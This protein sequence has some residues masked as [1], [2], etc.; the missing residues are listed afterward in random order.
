MCTKHT[1]IYFLQIHLFA[2]G[3]CQ[4]VNLIAGLINTMHSGLFAWS[5][6]AGG[7]SAQF[8]CPRDCAVKGESIGKTPL[9]LYRANIQIQV[10][11]QR[12]D[13]FALTFRFKAQQCINDQNLNVLHGLT[14][15]LK[16]CTKLKYFYVHFQWAGFPFARLHVRGS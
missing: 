13:N 5:E 12:S 11:Q 9:D 16:S 8:T 15:N 6:I 4:I 2:E 10:F 7:W 14:K 3:I 1:K